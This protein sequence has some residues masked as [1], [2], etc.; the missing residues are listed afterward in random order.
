MGRPT[1]GRDPRV[2]TYPDPETNS[3]L[4]PPENGCLEY[5]SASFL[6]FPS[7]SSFMGF[8]A[9]AVKLRVCKSS[10]STEQKFS[11]W[12]IRG[13]KASLQRKNHTGNIQLREKLSDFPNEVFFV[14]I[15]LIQ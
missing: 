10:K 14:N 3:K 5:D 4:K 1:A 7:S 15:N 13:T 8:W 11:G 12:E 2:A 6:G 9:T